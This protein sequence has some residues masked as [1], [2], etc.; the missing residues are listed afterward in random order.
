QSDVVGVTQKT[1]I[2]GD[3]PIIGAAFS[4]KS[5]QE[6][7]AELV[8]LITPYLVDPMACNQLPKYYPGQE[9][10][11]P[12]DYELFLEGILEAPR[13]QGELCPGGRYQPAYRNGPTAEIFP[14]GTYGHGGSNGSCGGNGHGS[15]DCL[16]DK[17]AGRFAA[18]HAG[19]S[20]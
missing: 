15:G 7:E 16:T 8:V 11:S 3:L 10:R 12:D 18:D 4:S 2:L 14:C 19:A 20:G 9:T 1:P 17:P 13:G 5:Y 6:R